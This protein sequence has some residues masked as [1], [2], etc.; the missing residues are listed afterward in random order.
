MTVIDQLEQGVVSGVLA[1]LSVV[2]GNLEQVH[3]GQLVVAHPVS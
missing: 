2:E 1:A 3:E